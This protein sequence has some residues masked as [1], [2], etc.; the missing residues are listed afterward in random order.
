MF[1]QHFHD[2]PCDAKIVH[3]TVRYTGAESA[4]LCIRSKNRILRPAMGL[5][6]FTDG[7]GIHQTNLSLY[8]YREAAGKG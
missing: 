3:S 1:T 5:A 7:S 2:D 4:V 8:N 6:R